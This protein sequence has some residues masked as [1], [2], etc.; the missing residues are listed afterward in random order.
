[1]PYVLG[2]H[3]QAY[4]VLTALLVPT[5]LIRTFLIRACIFAPLQLLTSARFRQ[6][7]SGLASIIAK[8]AAHFK[9]KKDEPTSKPMSMF[10]GGE[11][12]KNANY[13]LAGFCSV[14]KTSS[15]TGILLIRSSEKGQRTKCQKVE[16]VGETLTRNRFW[17]LSRGNETSEGPKLGRRWSCRTWLF[18][19]LMRRSI[20]EEQVFFDFLIFSSD[21]EPIGVGSS[22]LNR[23]V[24][25]VGSGLKA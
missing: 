15:R 23:D 16:M 17:L 1:M 19:Q 5:D 7:M 14:S 2:G 3:F 10:D 8:F 22:S 13:G 9:A 20:L 24:A 6:K 18:W 25:G 4:S 12:T 11:I 21:G